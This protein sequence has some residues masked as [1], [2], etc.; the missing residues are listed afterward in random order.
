[1]PNN[2]AATNGPTI[3]SVLRAC[4]AALQQVAAY[5]LPPALDRRLLWLSENKESLTQQE[6]EELL[7]LVDLAQERTVEKLRARLVLKQ[8]AEMLPHLHATQ[9]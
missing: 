1:M 3:D 7:E 5:R 6:R 8:I 4:E 2:I 9:S